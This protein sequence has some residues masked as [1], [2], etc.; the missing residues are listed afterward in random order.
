MTIDLFLLFV[1]AWCYVWLS[2]Q[3]LSDT[4]LYVGGLVTA[5]YV[6]WLTA[7]V[8]AKWFA[9]VSSQAFL[10]MKGH[11][12]FDAKTV[13]TLAWW[14]P[15]Q[16]VSTIGV[17][18]QWIAL[19]IVRTLAFFCV[20]AAVFLSFVSIVYLRRAIWDAPISQVAE[21]ISPAS[22]VLALVAASYVVLLLAFLLNDFAW[23]RNAVFL[24]GAIKASLVMHLIADATTHV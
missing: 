7:D 4:V 1:F 2:R 22:A 8:V 13:S 9:P 18:S 3:Q 12:A 10:W 20:T 17:E 15:A 5:G 11:L 19:H 21:K 14:L 24:V 16:P 6:A 23:F